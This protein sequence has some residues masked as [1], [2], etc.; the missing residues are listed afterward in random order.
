MSPTL[1][2]QSLTSGGQ[3]ANNNNNMNSI[4]KTPFDWNIVNARNGS[5][6]AQLAVGTWYLSGIKGA[7]KDPAEGIKWFEKAAK[8]GSADAN[9]N[10]GLVY[11]KGIGVDKDPKKAKEYFEKAI[12]GGSSDAR[13]NLAVVYMSGVLG[14]EGHKKAFEILK[15]SVAEG[16]LKA[17]QLSQAISLSLDKNKK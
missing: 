1:Y 16:D 13:Y 6:R 2:A 12:A 17:T 15:P 11:I 9:N 3:G 5:I 7:P 10:L 14:P 8:Q 4:Y